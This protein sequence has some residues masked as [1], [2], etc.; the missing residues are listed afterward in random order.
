MK[1]K[2]KDNY[3]HTL[4]ASYIGYVVQAIVNNFA[5]L[6]FLTFASAYGLTLGRITLV[7]TVNFLVQLGVD[8]LSAKLI[9]KIGCRTAIVTAHILSGAGMIGLAVLPE[10][11]GNPY[12]GL[13]LATVLCAI[14][15]GI[16]EVLISP[17]VEACSTEKKEAA[18]SLLHSFYCWGH[19]LVILLS[20]AFFYIAGIENWRI[21]AWVWAAIP[22]ANAVCFSRVPIYPLTAEHEK[23]SVGE[24]LSRKTFWVIAILMACAGAS[25]QAMSQWASAFA[26]AGLGVSKTLGD[27]AG[28]C[29]FGICMGT[30]RVLYGK[31][32]DYL[33]LRK[34]MAGSAV[35]CVLCYAAAAF[36][37]AP[38]LGLAGCAL[39]GFSV[40]I[41]WPGTYSIAA[42][43]L[44]GGGTAMYAF[45]ALA[46][47][48]GCCAGPTVVGLAADAAGGNLKAGLCAAMAFPV[49][50]IMGLFWI[51]VKKIGN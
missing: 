24:L 3:E 34:M 45:L 39:C 38:V 6:L 2:K 31:Y 11:M 22:F 42:K 20:T 8:L 35:L 10:L 18:M 12:A 27:L 30:A 9:D 28:P 32:S 23:I 29:A 15:G 51:E 5:P 14:G 40:G 44:K 21:L 46:G 47:D 17:M 49:V 37:R 1:E 26:E 50:I 43:A 25:E 13:M 36:A 33:P 41:F 4:Y 19:V 48:L 16:I 7:T